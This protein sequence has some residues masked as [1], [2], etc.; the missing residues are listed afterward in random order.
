MFTRLL[1]LFTIVPLIELSLLIQLGQHFGV[2]NTILL[3]ITT[4]VLGAYYAR[5]QG[6]YVISRIQQ[7]M[8]QG[9]MPGDSLL[10]GLLVF[11]GAL[12]LITPGLI[13]DV[14]GLALLVPVSRQL[15]RRYVKEYI[16]R[17]IRIHTTYSNLDPKDRVN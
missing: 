5:Q 9:Q 13:T 6:F 10:D 12:F 16:R 14:F 7:E 15:V 1:L 4:G 2:G 8:A 17:R 11:A 3:V